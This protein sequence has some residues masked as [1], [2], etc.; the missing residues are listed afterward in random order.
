ML[1]KLLVGL[2]KIGTVGYGGGAATMPL[3]KKEFIEKQGMLTE[4]EFI[5]I[6]A[7][8]NVLPG[9]LITKYCAVLGYRIKGI[10][11]AI[12]AVIAIILPSCL[13]L[14]VILSFLKNATTNEHIT[15]M[16]N[17]I[18]PVVTVILLMLVFDFFKMAKAKLSL[19]EIIVSMTVFGIMLL[20]LKLDAAVVIMIFVALCMLVPKREGE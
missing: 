13:M 1:I 5:E 2:L 14:L 12:L 20:G 8:C 7:I 3:M 10:I 15:N 4:E 9:P 19:K 11:G 18:F 6:L 17:A 16:V